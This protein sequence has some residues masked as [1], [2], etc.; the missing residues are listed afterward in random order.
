MSRVGSLPIT[1]PQGVEIEVTSSNVSVSGPKGKLSQKVLPDIKVVKE[2]G[3]LKVERESESKQAKAYHGLMRTL[4][5]NMVV[6]VTTGFEKALEFNGV[7]FRAKVEGEDLVLTMGYSHPVEI[8]APEGIKF[9]TEENRIYVGGYDKEKVGLLA[10]KIRS[11][12]PPEPYKGK[13]IKYIDE[14]I[15]RKVGKAGKVT[16]GGTGGK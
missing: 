2:E 9:R 12:R 5:N 6:G 7:G 3:I 14:I 16:T 1:I 15:R 13:G 4:I 8:K 11:V 10:A